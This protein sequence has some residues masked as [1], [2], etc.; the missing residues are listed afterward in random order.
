LQVFSSKIFY[1]LGRSLRGA[2]LIILLFQII[3]WN[4]VDKKFFIYKNAAARTKLFVGLSPP[5]ADSRQFSYRA[6]LPAVPAS[7]R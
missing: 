5:G 6:G 4:I 3:T 2:F 7:A 1:P